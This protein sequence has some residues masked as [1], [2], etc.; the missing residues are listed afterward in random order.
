[1]IAARKAP[2]LRLWNRFSIKIDMR[3]GHN[4]IDLAMV[5]KHRKVLWQTYAQICF[6]S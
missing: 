3:E 1:M 6:L 5:E 4:R 2:D